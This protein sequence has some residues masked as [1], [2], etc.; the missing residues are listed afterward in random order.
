MSF[1]LFYACTLN[2]GLDRLADRK[3]NKNVP[4][5]VGTTNLYG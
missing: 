4:E 2:Y 3:K 5:I 1:N